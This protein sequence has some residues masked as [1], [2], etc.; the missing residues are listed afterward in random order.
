M[1]S[2][3]TI[4]LM[5]LNLAWWIVIIQAVMSWLINFDVINLRQ[6]LVYQ[7]WSGLNRITEPVYRRIRAVIPPMGGLDLSPV[8]VLIGIMALQVII[9][10]NL[11][12]AY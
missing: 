1:H 5:I 2:L 9:A 11:L 12:H 6:P 4:L 8:I 10:N 3:A 7:I